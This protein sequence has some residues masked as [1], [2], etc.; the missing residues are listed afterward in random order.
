MTTKTLLNGFVV[1]DGN[2]DYINP[3][4]NQMATNTFGF[5]AWDSPF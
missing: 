3:G 4:C 1:S 2:P 5:G